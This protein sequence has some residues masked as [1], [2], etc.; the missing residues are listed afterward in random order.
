MIGKI[1]QHKINEFLY[2]LYFCVEK[3][4]K[5]ISVTLYK[6]F[7]YNKEMT[8]MSFIILT[9]SIIKMQAGKRSYEVNKISHVDVSQ[10]VVIFTI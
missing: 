7:L 2:Y 8:C 10:K 1:I 4:N 9:E 5:W 3:K 6:L